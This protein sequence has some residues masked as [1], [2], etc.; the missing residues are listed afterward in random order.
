MATKN[1]EELQQEVRIAAV[2]AT[3][4]RFLVDPERMKRWMG[5]SVT[6]DP[7]PGGIYKVNV[8]GRDIAR[9]EYL[10]VTQDSRVVFTWGWE[11]EGSPVPPGSST[12]EISLAPDGDGTIVRLRHSGLPADER[13]KHA[14]GWVHYMKRLVEAGEGRDPGPDPLTM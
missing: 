12:V 4:F 13:E 10:E 2:P 3:V 1:T 5:T 6:I 8:T 11:G 14:E 7:R 9:G